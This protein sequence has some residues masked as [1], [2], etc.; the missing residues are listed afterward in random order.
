MRFAFLHTYNNKYKIG[1]IHKQL[2][3]KPKMTPGFFGK[4]T[5]LCR[6]IRNRTKPASG[7]LCT[8]TETGCPYNKKS[9]RET[10]AKQKND[11]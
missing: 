5:F 10:L 3:R 11:M 9:G 6:R 2:T 7:D 8:F 4:K 1:K